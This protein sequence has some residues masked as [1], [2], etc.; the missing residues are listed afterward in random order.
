VKAY[1]VQRTN[2]MIGKK[3]IG[4]W[5][6]GGKRGTPPQLRPKYEINRRKKNEGP[7]LLV[8]GGK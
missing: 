8:I 2:G 4:L 6:K 1:Q 3:I 7:G 5:L